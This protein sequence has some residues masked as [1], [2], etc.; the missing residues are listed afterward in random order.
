MKRLK[1]WEEEPLVIP[2]KVVKAATANV[3][4]K[5]Q[6]EG[7]SEGK[8][9]T[10]KR[11]RALPFDWDSEEVKEERRQRCSDT[12]EALARVSLSQENVEWF[13][14]ESDM[15]DDVLKRY[16][17]KCYCWCKDEGRSGPAQCV[18]K[19]TR[20]EE[21]KPKGCEGKECFFALVTEFNRVCTH[22]VSEG[23]DPACEG[24]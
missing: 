24:L 4:P 11:G 13:T 14:V 16:Q 3:G 2:G 22:I 7:I 21:S 23:K 1:I 17:I 15:E 20:Q 18:C 6:G 12:E 9:R 10:S 19:K 8:K 5:L